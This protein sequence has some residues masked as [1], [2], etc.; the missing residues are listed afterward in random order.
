MRPVCVLALAFL[1][2]ACAGQSSRRDAAPPNMT[3]VPTVLGMTEQQASDRLSRAGLCPGIM[4]A[5]YDGTGRERVVE[6]DPAAG[7]RARIGATVKL[8]VV[9]SQSAE[10]VEGSG[11]CPSPFRFGS[12]TVLSGR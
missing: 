10:I 3:R 9:L 4:Y 7:A 8:G 6:Q 12:G 2:T 1:C 5:T 11:A